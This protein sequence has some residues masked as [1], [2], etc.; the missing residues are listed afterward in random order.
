MTF[1]EIV[2]I[3]KSEF[4]EEI[5]ISTDQLEGLMPFA[6]ISST[7]LLRIA[8]FLYTDPKCYFDYLACL[9]GMDNGIEKGTME[10]IYN[11][12][13]IAFD[14]KFCFKVIL[15]R[16]TQVD[17]QPQIESVSSIWRTAI[18]HEREIFDLFG[19]NFLNHPDMRRILLPADWEGYPLR[20][21][22]NLQEYYHGV[23]V[24]Y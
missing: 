7:D 22:Y 2:S 24:N 5:T 15:N 13:S 9:T 20:K 4:G 17:I 18:W 10:V 14:T 12:Y 11:L 16:P 6:T 23:K 19:I 3:L 21:D 1:Q 8:R